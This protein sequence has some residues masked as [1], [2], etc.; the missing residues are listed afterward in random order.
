[1]CAGLQFANVVRP[2]LL[3]GTKCSHDSSPGFIRSP[4]RQQM[5]PYLL[6]SSSVK[7]LRRLL[8]SVVQSSFMRLPPASIRSVLWLKRSRL[9][10][11]TRVQVCI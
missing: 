8:D 2:P 4:Q 6:I 10:N 11:V 9:A 5:L 1:M 7:A 3:R